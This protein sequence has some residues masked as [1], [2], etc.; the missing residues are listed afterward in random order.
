[1]LVTILGTRAEDATYVLGERSRTAK[2]ASLAILDLRGGID[3]VVA[4][5]TEEASRRVLPLLYEGLPAG[6]PRREVRVPEVSDPDEVE[7]FLRGVVDTLADRRVVLDLTHGPRHLALLAFAAA[8]YLAALGEVR[9]EGAYYGF[10]Q[11]GRPC[12][13]IPLEPLIELVRLAAAAHQFRLTGS[14]LGLLELLRESG[15]REGKMI[16]RGLRG[17]ASAYGSG[18]PLEVGREAEWFVRDGGERFVGWLRARRIPLGDRLA[19]AVREA[20]GPVSLRQLPGRK[21]WK[22]TVPLSPDELARQARFIDGLLAHES[23]APAVLAMEEWAISWAVRQIGREDTWLDR[24]SRDQARLAIAALAA[25]ASHATLRWRLTEEQ[26]RLAEWWQAIT[27]VRNGFAHAGMRAEEV[28]PW[29]GGKLRER[30]ARVRE[31]W[32]WLKSMPKVE[33]RVRGEIGRLLAAPVG[34][35]P[36]SLY[37]ALSLLGSVD[38]CLCVCS[39]ETQG[40]AREA[41]ERAGY[42][43]LPVE[44]LVFADPY[45]DVAGAEGAGERS[46]ELLARAEEVLVNLTG[47]TTLMGLAMERIAQEAAR[48]GRRVRRLIVIDPRPRAEQERDPYRLGRVVWVDGEEG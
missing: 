34:R 20:L 23:I 37:S 46:R 4:L 35:V 19:N 40:A 16:G 7:A 29:R 11:S 18:L 33:L 10:L 38:A 21:S 17:L 12:P 44:E 14:P 15:S 31:G 32:E 22:R 26:R 1:V 30:L 36:G 39:Q 13:L 42:P 27:E 45:G 43:D 25:H 5:C 41:L 47:G 3:E 48:L 24:S 2:L 8:A 28:A 6:L 9:V